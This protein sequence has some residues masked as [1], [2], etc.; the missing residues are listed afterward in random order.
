MTLVALSAVLPGL[1]HLAGGRRTAGRVIMAATLALL[2]SVAAL[3]YA[4]VAYPETVATRAAA[5]AL[6]PGCLGAVRYGVLTVGA[7]WVAV[8]LSA[9]LVVHPG[10]VPPARRLIAFALAAVLCTAVIAPTVALSNAA[11]AT[12]S[13]TETLF[14]G[15]VPESAEAAAGAQVSTELAFADGRVNVL[16]LGGD[17]GQGRQGLRTDTVIVASLD[18]ATGRVVLFSLPRNLQDIPFPAGSAMARAWPEGFDC[19]DECLLNAVYQEGADHAERFPGE[20]DPGAAAVRAGVGESLGLDLDYVVLVT[21]AGFE[22]IIDALGGVTIDVAERLPIGGLD[23]D[24]N[25]VRP[26]GY[27][28]AGTQ[29]MTGATALDYV[30]SRSAGTDYDR[31]ERQSC[32]LGAVVRQVDLRTLLTRYGDVLGATSDAVRT[33]ITRPAARALLDLAVKVRGRP[34]ERLAFIPPVIP[35]TTNPDF[36]RIRALVRTA[37][38]GTGPAGVPTPTPP[39]TPDAAT[40]DAATPDAATPDAATP[41]AATPDAATPGAEGAGAVAPSHTPGPEAVDL[42]GVC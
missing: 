22:T 36:V 9:V 24:G 12:Q 18:V 4:I 21:L 42:G 38:A 19:G 33:D 31:V 2:A 30:R 40:P 13:A 34:I 5:C 11:G 39:S 41:D 10:A 37:I 26:S 32:L 35:D 3:A 7:C 20:R 29:R 6:N 17:S 23:A 1:G 28:A 15:F 25:R 14:G 16:L 8:I 27:I